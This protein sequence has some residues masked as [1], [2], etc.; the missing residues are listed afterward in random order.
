MGRVR[1]SLRSVFSIG[2]YDGISPIAKE[3]DTNRL[4]REIRDGEEDK[5]KSNPYLYDWSKL[6]K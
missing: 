2:G 1:A 4:L 5:P 3:S 6:G